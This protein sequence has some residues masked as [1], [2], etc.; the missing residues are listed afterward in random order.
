MEGD[1]ILEGEGAEIMRN[2]SV[3]NP[4]L[5]WK[6]RYASAE[7]TGETEGATIVVFTSA[8]GTET[9]CHFDKASG[10][11]TKQAGDDPFGTPTVTTF[12]DYKKVGD[13]SVVHTLLIETVQG[14]IESTVTAVRV[15]VEIDDSTFDLPEV[16]AAM[17]PEEAPEGITDEKNS[18]TT[19]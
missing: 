19:P 6:E 13:I 5:N 8:G 7:V 10:L 11:L 4:L 9:T 2:M 12:S 16:I 18:Q 1:A 17:L 15:D 3:H 14:N